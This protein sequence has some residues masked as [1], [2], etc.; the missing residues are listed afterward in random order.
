MKVL[1]TIQELYE[2]FSNNNRF[3]EI[4][5]ETADGQTTCALINGDSGWLM[6]LREPGNASYSSRNPNYSG[7][8]IATQEY[9]L[10][11]GQR[12]E[13]P[14]SWALPI[15]EV[16]QALEFFIKEA[17]PAPWILW[18]NDSEDLEIIGIGK[19]L[20]DVT[21]TVQSLINQEYEKVS[22]NPIPGSALDQFGLKEGKEIIVDYLKYGE[23]GIALDHLVYML[24]ETKVQISSKTKDKIISAARSLGKVHEVEEIFESL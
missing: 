3:K 15:S 1:T 16:L 6:Y 24:I 9:Y 8:E 23:A 19:Q 7:S 11:N 4:W 20:I 21:T 10:D 17:K 22:N 12:D 5:A 13:Y 18:H 14:L 2:V